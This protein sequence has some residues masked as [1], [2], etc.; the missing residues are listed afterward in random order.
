MSERRICQVNL[1][2]IG[3]KM[4]RKKLIIYLIWC[5]GIA[6]ICDGIVI[7]N[8]HFEFLPG[9]ILNII[10][11]LGALAPTLSVVILLKKYGAI[12]SRK[13]ILHF[14]L[15]FPK[16]ILPYIILF[17]FLLWRFLVFWF[18]GDTTQAQPFYML[19]P[20]LLA[21]LFFQGGFEEPGWRG[22]MQ[23]YFEKKY[24]L[25]LSIV[26]VSIIWS[27]WHIPL[28]FVPGSAQSQMSFLIF[29]LQ[30]LVN[31]CSLAAILKL[32]NSVVF[33][34]IY[35]AWCNSVFLVI[36]FEMNTGIIAA[37]TFEAV[38]SLILCLIYNKR[39]SNL[40]EESLS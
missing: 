31:T 33:F 21:Q 24:P 5:F 26:L 37:Y 7:L 9:F 27:V 13:N 38:A 40:N 3:G 15:D 2:N 10:G 28:W 8:A 17:A 11:A 20:I 29:F 6:W 19:F 32:T 18:T 22:F 39:R 12:G 16:K 35:H 34:M 14:V 25:I 4:K 30:I 36:P 1:F 23:S